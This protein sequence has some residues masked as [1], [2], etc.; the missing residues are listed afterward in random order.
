[1]NP[2]FPI[3][4]QVFKGIALFTPGGDLVYCVDPDKQARWHV[5]LCGLLQQMLDLSA[6]PHFLVPCYT[7]TLDRWLDPVSQ[8][9]QTI[10]E[11]SPLVWRYRN[12]LN[13]IFDTP[14]VNWQAIR[15][16]ASTCDPALMLT[17]R[18][19]F[20]QLWEPQDL[21]VGV[22][23]THQS[24]MTDPSWLHA[25]QS[26]DFDQ[27]RD[28]HV[29]RLFV[30]GYSVSTEQTLRRV[31]QL[32]ELALQ[33]PYTLK[34]I[35]V[36]QHPEQAES[37]QITATPTL[38][39]IWPKPVRRIVGKLDTVDQITYLLRPKKEWLLSDE[40]TE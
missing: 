34:I 18:H 22:D 5:H 37:H 9:I 4:S 23:R 11:A 30:A 32:L 10:A 8:Q 20:P 14:N 3:S 7:A 38:I 19:Q 1:M 25:P 15:F 24:P 29:L 28:G 16:P 31:H 36:S 21:V 17:Y 40:E 6:P 2:T 13:S 12:I 35:D 33:E 26:T 27:A 39:R